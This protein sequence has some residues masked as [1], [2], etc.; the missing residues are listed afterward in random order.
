MNESNRPVICISELTKFNPQSI[1]LVRKHFDIYPKELSTT[2]IDEI[3]HK[4]DAILLRLGIRFENGKP[5]GATRCKYIASPTTGIDHIDLDFCKTHDIKIISLKGETEFLKSIRATAEHT[6]GLL[7]A[8]IRQI[9]PAHQSVMNG[10]F[11][12][13]PFKG[14]ELYEKTMGIIGYGRLGQIVALYA[15][16]FGMKLLIYDQQEAK[17]QLI[18]IGERSSLDQLLSSS[19]IVSLHVDLNEL[20]IKMANKLFFSKMKKNA[21]FINT[22]RGQLVDEGALLNAL[23]TNQLSGAALDVV[24]D[25]PNPD[26]DSPLYAFAKN[27]H[28]LLIT[29]HIGGNT[30]ESTDKAEKFIIDKLVYEFNHA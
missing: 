15:T 22:S 6:F 8:L 11:D 28:R 5:L 24:Q 27:S 25:E 4:C 29:P 21:I 10:Q 3:L 17:N 19:D 20:N 18:P 30:F 16:G 14:T 2:N 23:E 7:L 12:R 1:D 13:N 26:V 9:V